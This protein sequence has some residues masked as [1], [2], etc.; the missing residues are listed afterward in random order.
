MRNRFNLFLLVARSEIDSRSFSCTL[1]FP[2]VF[3]R[4]RLTA[5]LRAKAF[6]G[7]SVTGSFFR[8]FRCFY[9]ALATISQRVS[10]PFRSRQV[11]GIEMDRLPLAVL[12][13]T[14][15]FF[16][17]CTFIEEAFVP[18]ASSEK[19]PPFLITPLSTERSLNDRN[20]C[21]SFYGLHKVS[22]RLTFFLKYRNSLPK[23]LC[24]LRWSTRFLYL[25]N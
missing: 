13:I 25:S 20:L 4:H 8:S 14:I 22:T 19:P 18:L 1:L 17:L 2:S 11:R 5:E 9:S 7:E 24:S 21:F 12:P 6:A 3:R 16:N 10:T 23:S 15:A